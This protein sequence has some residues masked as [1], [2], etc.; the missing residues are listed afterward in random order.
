MIGAIVDALVTRGIPMELIVGISQGWKLYGAI[1]TAERKLAEGKLWHSGQELMAWCVGN[2]KV[3]PRGNAF[4][5]TKQTSGRA[6][7]DPLMA[8]F[9]AV[10]L[11]A[12]DPASK[13]GA[14][15]VFF[16]GGPDLGRRAAA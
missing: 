6:K 11:M 7:I 3:E 5:I 12:L 9:N 16:V 8:M 15:D 4:L 14:F 13:R 10:Q 1:Q 2:A